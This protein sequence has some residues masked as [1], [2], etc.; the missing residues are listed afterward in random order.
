M[1]SFRDGIFLFTAS[2]LSGRFSNIEGISIAVPR[3]G[4]G[5]FHEFSHIQIVIGMSIDLAVF[6]MRKRGWEKTSIE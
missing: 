6:K 4:G 3:L 1:S 5:V 2:E